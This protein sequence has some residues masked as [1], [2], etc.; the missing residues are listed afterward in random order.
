MFATCR[1]RQCNG[2]VSGEVTD[3]LE[4]IVAEWRLLRVARDSNH[5]KHR[6][7]GDQRHDDRRAFTDVGESLDRILEGIGDQRYDRD[8][9][10]HPWWSRPSE[11][12]DRSPPRRTGPP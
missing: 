10:H 6:V 12:A 8:A 4:V 9:R 5:T 2:S 1:Q 3:E 11:P 7:I